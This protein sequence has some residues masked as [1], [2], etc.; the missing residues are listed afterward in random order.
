MIIFILSYI[1]FKVVIDESWMENIDVRFSF[2]LQHSLD[3][4]QPPE[5]NTM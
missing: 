1:Y 4:Y 2:Y 3:N 5:N